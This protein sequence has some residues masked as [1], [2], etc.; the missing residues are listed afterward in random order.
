M[1]N[2]SYDDIFAG[3]KEQTPP[4]QAQPEQPARE[5]GQLS[6][7]EYAAKKQAERESLNELADD[8]AMEIAGDGDKFK[9]YLDTLA[10]FERYSA[11][12]TLL[13]YAQKPEA[14]RLGDYEHWKEAETP[15]RK[16]QTG[17][18]IYEPGEQYTREDGSIGTS[19]N[20]K[21]VFDISQ[22]SAK[23]EPTPQKD[24]RTLLSALMQTSPVPVKLVN[25]LSGADPG[26]RGAEYQRDKGVI[27]LTRGMDGEDIYRSLSNEIAMAQ[28]DRK[29]TECRDDGFVAYAASYVL[30]KKHGVDVSDYEFS[31][32]PAY[33][34]GQDKDEVRGELAAVRDTANDMATRMARQL[35]PKKP[36]E[37]GARS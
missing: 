20:V 10:K 35:E 26:I 28:L 11:Q 5:E 16:G 22:T 9:G 30:A 31:D 27:E 2:S 23:V 12:N 19:F 3:A 21:R 14:T 29:D 6:K 4:E 13:I 34:E 7:E 17:I 24:I 33:F 18:K 1:A 36:P 32:A 37:Q 25:E 8:A 15:V